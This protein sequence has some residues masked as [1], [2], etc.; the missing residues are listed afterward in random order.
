[1]ITRNQLTTT[2]PNTLILGIASN[3]AQTAITGALR[4]RNGGMEGDVITMVGNDVWQTID[5]AMN[6]LRIVCHRHL[7]I[8]TTC[9]EIYTFLQRPIHV[10]QPDAKKVWVGRDVF[11]VRT[12]GNVHQWSIL[13]HLFRY[14][15]RCERV[16]ALSKA[17]GLLK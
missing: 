3:G 9:E 14:V 10:E 12:G 2:T 11:T 4:L 8:L 16:A 17:E 13:R 1:M 5:E 7:M 6:E 15:W